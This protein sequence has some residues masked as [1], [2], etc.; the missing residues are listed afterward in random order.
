[1]AGL[2]AGGTCSTVLALRNPRLFPTFASF[3]GFAT[4]TYLDDTVAESVPVLYDG[5]EAAYL[6]HD[7]DDPAGPQQYPDTA[8]WFEAG[9][10]RPVSP[11]LTPRDWPPR[12]GR[13]GCQRCA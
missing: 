10:E 13:P 4:P 5:S 12:P 11:G 9:T 8:A 1:M 7:P 6:A 3:S 2:S